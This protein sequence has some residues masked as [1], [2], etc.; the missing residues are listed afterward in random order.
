[1]H[2]PRRHDAA[3]AKFLGGLVLS[4]EKQLAVSRPSPRLTAARFPEFLATKVLHVAPT[5]VGRGAAAIAATGLAAYRA[6]RVK[7]V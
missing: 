2:R 1:M 5:A 3:S 4:D 7:D 6:R